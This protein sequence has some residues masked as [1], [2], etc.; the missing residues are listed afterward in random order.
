[1][2][3]MTKESIEASIAKAEA[4][5]HA[6]RLE[7]AHHDQTLAQVAR[8]AD[9]DVIPLKRERTLL[10]GQRAAL[11]N[12]KKAGDVAPAD[13]DELDRDLKAEVARLATRIDDQTK[14]WRAK[15]KVEADDRAKTEK[16]LVELEAG[17]AI[18]RRL[19]ARLR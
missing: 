19:L 9:E 1:M 17:L 7:L 6:K 12:R 2:A 16:E 10:D 14:A 15:H 4:D 18:D 5:V 8:D 11:A 3:P 13:A